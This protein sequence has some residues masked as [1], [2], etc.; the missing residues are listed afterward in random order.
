MQYY[1]SDKETQ[2]GQYAI[3]YFRKPRYLSERKKAEE[4]EEEDICRQ[5]EFVKDTAAHSPCIISKL[6]IIFKQP[7]SLDP[8]KVELEAI[9]A[10]IDI[11]HLKKN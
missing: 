2:V 4:K 8:R 11:F 6:K 9:S 5:S 10:G 1:S 7:N 3:K